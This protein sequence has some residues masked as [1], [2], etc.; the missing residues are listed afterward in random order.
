[1]GL[2]SFALSPMSLGETKNK[3]VFQDGIWI[4]GFPDSNSFEGQFWNSVLLEDGAI[5]IGKVF[6]EVKKNVPV[7]LFVSERSRTTVRVIEEVRNE[8]YRIVVGEIGTKKLVLLI[9]EESISLFDE[10]GKFVETFVR[11]GLDD[12]DSLRR[13][14]SSLKIQSRIDELIVPKDPR[15]E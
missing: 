12:P 2:S 7:R 5:V 14:V 10:A 13:L 8:A 1:M 9:R 11:R 6:V 15:Q 4:S 3:E